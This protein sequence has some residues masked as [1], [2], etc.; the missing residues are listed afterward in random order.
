[1]VGRRWWP[2]RRRAG[3]VED[4]V[5]PATSY[6]DLRGC[7][8]PGAA[9]VEQEPDQPAWNAPTRFDGHGLLTY[10]QRRQYRV[11][12]YRQDESGHYRRLGGWR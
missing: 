10:G 1:M 11:R 7:Y 9:P 8:G 12:D 5:G 6:P 2:W 3:Q 4:V